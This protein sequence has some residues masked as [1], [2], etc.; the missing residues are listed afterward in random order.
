MII[1]YDDQ[2]VNNTFSKYECKEIN[3]TTIFPK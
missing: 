2:K 3:K 1:D